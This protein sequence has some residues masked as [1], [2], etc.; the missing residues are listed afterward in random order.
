VTLSETDRFLAP[1]H[2]FCTEIYALSTRVREVHVNAYLWKQDSQLTKPG[3][4]SNSS[5][6]GDF[7]AGKLNIFQPTEFTLLSTF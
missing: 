4:G 6:A 2:R 5:F 7:W 3:I 1:A